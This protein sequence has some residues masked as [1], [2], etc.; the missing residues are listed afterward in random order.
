MS[1]S[2]KRLVISEC[3]KTAVFRSH[4]SQIVFRLWPIALLLL[5]SRAFAQSAP[6][7]WDDCV[8]LASRQNPDLLS[9]V[10]ASEASQATYRGSFNGIL[11]HLALNNSYTDASASR[12][13]I[14]NNGTTG[15]VTTET[16]LWQAEG[17][18]SLDLVDFNQW[19]SIQ[20][21]SASLHQS[22]ANVK[23]AASNALL[24][25]YKSFSALLYAQEEVRV[26]TEI[27]DTWKTNADMVGLRYKSGS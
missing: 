19:A 10:R 14:L 13:A 3:R 2:E 18:A 4:Y 27:R 11:P 16:K 9:A 25:L 20:S 22:Q 7:T 24:N 15:I 21:A 17:V 26:N 6:L 8:R 23:V 12:N 1:I 5:A